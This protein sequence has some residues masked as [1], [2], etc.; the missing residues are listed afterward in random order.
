MAVHKYGS[1]RREVCTEIWK[2]GWL[3]R[4]M[5]AGGGIAVRKYGSRRRDGCTEI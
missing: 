4:N 3:Y 1:R 5:K 2:K